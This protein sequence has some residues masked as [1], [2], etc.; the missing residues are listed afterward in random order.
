MKKIFIFFFLIISVTNA[1]NYYNF[2]PNSTGTIRLYDS[3][4]SVSNWNFYTLD[5]FRYYG[6]AGFMEL[7]GTQNWDVTLNGNN[8]DLSLLIMNNMLML[9]VS[10]L[11]ISSAKF[12]N[13]QC[14]INGKY[15]S[16]GAIILN[17]AKPDNG[18]NI[19][20]AFTLANASGDPGPYEFIP[21]ERTFN[22]EE[23]G[24]DL[25]TVI[26]YGTAAFSTQLFF[27]LSFPSTR[28]PAFQERNHDFSRAEG[29]SWFR[30]TYSTYSILNRYESGNIKVDH[31]TGY[32][33]TNQS[34]Y[35]MLIE[36]QEETDQ[37]Y[38]RPLSKE[39]VFFD[40]KFINNLSGTYQLNNNEQIG[41]GLSYQKTNV[42]NRKESVDYDPALDKTGISGKVYFTSQNNYSGGINFEY[43]VYSSKHFKENLSTAVTS[44]FIEK[45][46]LNTES[47]E[48]SSILNLKL[49]GKSAGINTGLAYSQFISENF[50]FNLS[51]NYDETIPA[52]NADYWYLQN[53]GFNFLDSY[54]IPHGETSIPQ[55][56][57]VTSIAGGFNY[58]INKD[59]D[60]TFDAGYRYFGNY[61]YERQTILDYNN[62]IPEYYTEIEKNVSADILFGTIKITHKVLQN[63]DYSVSY[64]TFI[65]SLFSKRFNDADKYPSH[66]INI[67]AVY[68]PEETFRIFTGIYFNS[69]TE[70]SN[71]PVT[72]PEI[73]SVLL[74]N[75]SF[76][77]LLFN[78]K[79]E[80]I[81]NYKN[82]L[83]NK[84]KFFP[85]GFEIPFT[86]TFTAILRT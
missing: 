39:L 50:D 82:I 19:S 62:G 18:F 21:E 17:T 36:Y 24:R 34:L 20:T 45:T 11:Q 43:S 12:L 70:W 69:K 53:A 38:F 48:L 57:Y 16:K 3:Y 54:N 73:P 30:A 28:Y 9:P 6:N 75:A 56:Y 74:W 49:A 1:Q 8:V 55:K 67:E 66:K 22:I 35:N 77:K 37:L 5:Y 61:Y 23:F 60:F 63:L 2:E 58:G 27:G 51:F 59:L 32:S 4:L 31:L 64:S 42:Y 7:N 79:L 25:N 33:S 15:F 13:R 83:D 78:R 80:L 46:L 86:L 44:V 81:V 14:R 65:Q 40:D 72:D 76:S 10:V 71:Y 85:A 47:K 29:N 84:I 26:S 68:F 52:E 41:A